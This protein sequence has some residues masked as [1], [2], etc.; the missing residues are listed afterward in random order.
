M[1]TPYITRFIQYTSLDIS[2]CLLLNAF[3]LTFDVWFYIFLSF[4][5]CFWWVPT[6]YITHKVCISNSFLY[7]SYIDEYTYAYAR[8][9]RCI[10]AEMC[11]NNSIFSGKDEAQ[12][13]AYIFQLCG[14]PDKH[15]EE[16]LTRLSNCEG[17]NL[18]MQ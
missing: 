7:I 5:P 18:C 12:Q 11:R 9:F 10:F 13:L 1:F 16:T 14:T 6:K 4:C 8:T 15:D 17:S 3:C 2:Y